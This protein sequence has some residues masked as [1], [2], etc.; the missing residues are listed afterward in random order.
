MMVDPQDQKNTAFTCPFGDFAYRKTPLGLCNAP[1]TFQ[2]YMFAI[3]A[4][5][6]E[7]CIEVFMDD[8]LVFGSSFNSCLENLDTVLK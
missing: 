7:K 4:S 6:M 8:F 1:T 3:F 2:Q 5:L